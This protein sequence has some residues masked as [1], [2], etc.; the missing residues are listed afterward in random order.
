MG[1]L[2]L[3][4]LLLRLNPFTGGKDRYPFLLGH[5][6]LPCFNPLDLIRPRCRVPLNEAVANRVVQNGIEGMRL[7]PS[8]EHGE[9]SW[10]PR[11]AL[12]QWW[13]G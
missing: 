3:L 13:N 10:K 6:P 2:L 1:N 11:N 12:H 5:K 7:R 8:S 9:S 4:V